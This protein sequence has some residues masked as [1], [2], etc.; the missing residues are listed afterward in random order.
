MRRLI[1]RR[2]AQNDIAAA[3]NRAFLNS[4]RHAQNLLDAVEESLRLI[5]TQPRLYAV[6]ENAVRRS[7]LKGVP[8]AL[9]Y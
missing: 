5:E 9:L 7:N 4:A 2:E 1:L 6:R 8:F 3:H